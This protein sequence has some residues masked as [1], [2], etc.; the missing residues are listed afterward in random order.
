MQMNERETFHDMRRGMVNASNFSIY[1]PWSEF[2]NKKIPK[3][4]SGTYTDTS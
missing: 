1:L 4:T 3:E 2:K